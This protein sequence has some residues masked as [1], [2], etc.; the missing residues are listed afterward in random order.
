MKAD[1]ERFR[2]EIGTDYLDVL[3]MSITEPDWTEKTGVPGS[4]RSCTTPKPREDS[5]CRLSCHNVDAL[6]K[7]AA[8]PHI[9][10]IRPL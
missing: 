8:S 6:R 9:D 5:R 3:L 1:I 4:L 10:A 2:H 7:A